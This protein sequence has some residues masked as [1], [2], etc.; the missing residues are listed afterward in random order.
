MSLFY[1]TTHS[2]LLKQYYSTQN[3]DAIE[4]SSSKVIFSVS[5]R[6]ARIFKTIEEAIKIMKDKKLINCFI[7]DQNGIQQKYL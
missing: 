1:I 2:G 5:L 4:L 6:G 7:I 3:L